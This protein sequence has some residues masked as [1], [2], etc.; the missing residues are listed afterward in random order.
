L[1]RNT[2]ARVPPL[3]HRGRV[4]ARARIL[5][6]KCIF[7]GIAEIEKA[8]LSI[9][10]EVCHLS[11]L[12]RYLHGALTPI[13]LTSFRVLPIGNPAERAWDALGQKREAAPETTGD[14]CN[15]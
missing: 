7:Q 15:A 4:A 11:S 1:L 6:K 12:F 8:H 14:V 5:L 13:F 9:C 3:E 2:T 10:T